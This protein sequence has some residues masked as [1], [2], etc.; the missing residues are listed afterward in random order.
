MTTRACGR[1]H[2]ALQLPAICVESIKKTSVFAIG[3]C[4]ATSKPSSSLSIVECNNF[5]TT[6][7]L[8]VV[9]SDVSD[10]QAEEQLD[11]QLE[12]VIRQVRDELELI[13]KMIGEA[14]SAVMRG[15]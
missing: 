3:G 12:L 5:V 9:D 8:K 4:T 7:R 13:P 2:I 1:D 15:C 14:L 6:C 11:N 10:E